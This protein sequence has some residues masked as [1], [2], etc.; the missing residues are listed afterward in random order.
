MIKT[1]VLTA[2]AV[3]GVT[4]I[5]AVAAAAAPIRECG[6]ISEVNGHEVQGSPGAS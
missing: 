2:V 4:C 1:R 3:A 6:T 5:A